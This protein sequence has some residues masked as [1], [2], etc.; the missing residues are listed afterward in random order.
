MIRGINIKELKK[1]EDARGWLAEI[2]REDDPEYS[3]F[4]PS[5][6]YISVTKPG[7]A[8]G[9]H[10]HKEQS[11]LFVFLGPG[12]FRL[13]TLGQPKRQPHLSRKNGIGG[14]RR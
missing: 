7:V 8:R 13:Y 6:S 10:E 2:Y 3:G 9:P 12:K 11:D 14:R 4:R 1:N 5:M